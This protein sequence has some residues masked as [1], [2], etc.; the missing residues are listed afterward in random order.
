MDQN[1]IVQFTGKKRVDVDPQG[2]QHK[3]LGGLFEIVLRRFKLAVHV[4]VLM[5]LYGLAS[6]CIGASLVPGILF[7]RLMNELTNQ[8]SNLVHTAALGFSIAAGFFLYGFTMMF[9]IPAVNYVLRGQLKPWR[10]TY[11]SLAALPWSVHNGLTY[12]MRYTFLE[13]I[14]PTP[15]N[16]LFY[17]LMGMKIGH[18]TQINSTNISDPS[19]IVLGKRV[20]I[21]GSA[22]LC[23]HYGMSGYL[24]LAPVVIGD[25]AVIGLRAIV[26]GGVEIGA[27]A[28][29]LPNSVVMP[30]TVIPA[31]EIWGGVPA[32][33]ITENQVSEPK[34]IR[35]IPEN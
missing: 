2:S 5:L 18:G 17:K 8:R 33:K 16:L 14:T 22:T 28:K 11:Y 21:G 23:G 32:I 29:V 13:F 26:M 3:G 1:K 25:D 35:A 6:L 19:L 7:Y 34:T 15:F 12:L 31:G 4:S 10:G 30:K 20:T 24:I 9:L 27:S